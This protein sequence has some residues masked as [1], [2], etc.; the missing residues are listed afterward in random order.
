MATPRFDFSSIRTMPASSGI[1]S[2]VLPCTKRSYWSVIQDLEAW[3]GEPTSFRTC[4]RSSAPFAGRASAPA[5]SAWSASCQDG[6]A[7][8]R[9]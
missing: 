3:F 1:A 5:S 2:T 8:G 7:N 4:S 6:R 9:W